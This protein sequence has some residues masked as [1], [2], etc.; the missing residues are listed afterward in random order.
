MRGLS[1]KSLKEISIG[2]AIIHMVRGRSSIPPILF[3]LAVELDHVF[4]SNW[5]ITKLSRLGFCLWWEEVARYKQ[6][7]VENEN[8]AN[9]LSEYLPGAFTQWSADNVD[10][11][12]RTLDGKG[13]FHVMVLVSSTTG[14]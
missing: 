3:G 13:T 2:Q 14:T 11:N 6:S 5:L 12:I 8:V 7:V 9:Y 10:H 1:K 4:G